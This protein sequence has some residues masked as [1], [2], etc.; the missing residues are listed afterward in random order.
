M[1]QSGEQTTARR[2]RLRRFDPFWKT[3]I[4]Y[5]IALYLIDDGGSINSRAGH[6]F[7]LWSERV[8][9][10]LMT[11]EYLFR[12]QRTGRKY[13]ASALAQST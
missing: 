12:W 13:P 8:V 4:W 11:L 3:L 2:L 5:S 7:F 1:L 6:P 9:A 10:S